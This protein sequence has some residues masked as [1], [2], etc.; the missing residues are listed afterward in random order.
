MFCLKY[1]KSF[2]IL[3]IV[4]SF[5]I[6]D[7]VRALT[8]SP[9]L[10]KIEIAPGESKNQI[11]TLFNETDQPITFYSQVENFSANKVTN[12]PVFLGNVEAAGAARWF[13]VDPVSIKLASGEQKEV[14]IKIVA[15]LTAE[16]GGHYAAVLWSDVAPQDGG[17]KT[18]SR[19]ASLFLLTVKGEINENLQ[20]ISFN[21]V[22]GE[23][24]FD[25]QIEN[26]GNVHLQPAGQLQ[27]LNRQ[28]KVVAVTPINLLKQNILP[29]S[30]RDFSLLMGEKLPWGRYQAKVQIF[31]G[32]NQMVESSKIVF[33]QGPENVGYSLLS[34]VGILLIG[35][36]IYKIAKRKVS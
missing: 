14:S 4:L 22:A 13:I 18:T 3:F 23:N 11:V 7:Q 10:T 9:S 6:V 33:W 29:Q 17:V 8:I 24:K 35:G 34:L 30:R 1:K 5:I 36:V 21:K 25:L 27:I 28:G 26:Q 2:F 32:Q 15:S 16:P 31:F 19:V 20:I 12:T